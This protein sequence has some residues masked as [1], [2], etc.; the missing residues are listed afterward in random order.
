MMWFFEVGAAQCCESHDCFSLLGP[1]GSRRLTIR[2]ISRVLELL[3]VQLTQSGDLV[4]SAKHAKG[5]VLR[6]GVQG[7]SR[8]WCQPLRIQELRQVFGFQW[9]PKPGLGLVRMMTRART[10]S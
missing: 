5:P 1:S 6:G 4:G 3:S 10:R 7:P 2:S 8:W 9:S